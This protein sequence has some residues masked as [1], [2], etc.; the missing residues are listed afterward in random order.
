[1]ARILCVEDQP[2]LRAL[3]REILEA[4]TSHR[5]DDAGTGEEAIRRLAAVHDGSPLPDLVLLDVGLPDTSGLDLLA[6]LRERHVAADLPIIMITGHN[7]PDVIK[8]AFD[9][10]ASDFIDK[11]FYP[12]ELIARVTNLLNL[13]EEHEVRG[14]REEELAE[15]AK[16]L[17]AQTW[18]LARANSM[19]QAFSMLDPLLGIA[20][21]RGFD[22]AMAEQWSRAADAGRPLSL[23][24]V[25]VDRFK[26]INDT[27]GHPTGDAALSAIAEALDA[28]AGNGSNVVARYGGDEFAVLLPN[29]DAAGATCVASQA[30]ERIASL[31]LTAP[32]DD[33]GL[34]LSASIGVAT[35]VPTM[36]SD[37]STLLAE[38]D[39]AVYAAKEAGR[40]CVRTA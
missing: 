13:K 33:R 25:D 31:R 29:A 1:M 30:C 8:A 20:N 35:V 26:G 28:V 6:R 21:R 17:E 7:T 2:L 18:E 5:I 14:Q 37:P 27:F 36:G 24:F 12:E 15:Q 38:A 39:E 10:G 32:D 4:R 34:A 19:L 11:P 3:I 22:S 23:M 9:A 40:G 16:R